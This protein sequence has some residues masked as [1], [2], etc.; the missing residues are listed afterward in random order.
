MKYLLPLV[1]LLSGCA[2]TKRDIGLKV[3]CPL[4]TVE[5]K[6]VAEGTYLQSRPNV[7]LKVE[8]ETK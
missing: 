4:F 3:N 6:S 1:L 7:P 5:W 8:D 2:A